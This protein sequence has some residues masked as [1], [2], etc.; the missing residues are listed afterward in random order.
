MADASQNPSLTATARQRLGA[1]ISAFAVDLFAAF[2]NS[3]SGNLFVSPYSIAAALSM[4]QAGA[5]GNTGAELA[6]ALHQPGGGAHAEMGALIAE[7]NGAG[8]QPRSYRLAVANRLFGATGAKFLPDFLAVNAN[9]YG[10]PLEQL[11]F[12]N[13]V[14]PARKHINE[15]VEGKTESKIRELILPG[16]LTRDAR[17]VLV[18]AIYFRADW[19][20]PFVK[21]F[22]QDAPFHLAAGGQV[23]VPLMLRLGEFPY[24]EEPGKLQVAELPYSGGE[25]SMVVVLPAEKVGLAGIE[26]SITVENIQKWTASLTSRNVKVQ[27]PRFKLTWGT[28]NVIPQLEQLGI[29]DAFTF[30]KADFSGMDGGRSLVISLVLH[31]AF[32]DVSEQGTEAAAA[33]AVVAAPGGPPPAMQLPKDFKADRPFIFLI[34][35]RASGAILF[36]G[37]LADP[38]AADS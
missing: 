22:T 32:V 16:Q 36:M 20:M 14:E 6:R 8:G 23:S 12:A 26:S 38:R 18:N 1:G 31:K 11:D 30:P 35:H 27:L 9:Q 33:T 19:A 2:K 28:K 24:Y 17:L 4:T 15:W 3:E 37:R 13:A 34:R 21:S 7:L 5:R 10:A 25:L 29:H